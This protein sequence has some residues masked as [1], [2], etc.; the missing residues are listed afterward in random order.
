[1]K[2]KILSL[3]LIMVTLMAPIY[4]HGVHI[5]TS[6]DAQV[7][8]IADESTAALA[9]KVATESS[10]TV[11][12]FEFTSLSQVS[13]E[14]DHIIN[15]YNLKV[16]A[17]AYQDTVQEF[18]SQNPEAKE[19][20]RISS[21]DE[22]DIKNNIQE[23]AGENTTTSV[24]ENA[25]E[26]NFLVPFLAGILIGLIAGLGAGVFFMQRKATLKD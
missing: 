14:L 26:D 4:A 9:Q 20:I 11:E 15:D 5:S 24:N 2:M 21:A 13:H 17:V 6:T 23:L 18:I 22:E 25:E 1:M 16:V 3:I 7:V 12:V 8:I 10:I 19:Q